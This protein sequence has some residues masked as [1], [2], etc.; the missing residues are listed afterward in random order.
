[1]PGFY[2]LARRFR[3][4]EFPSG[5]PK[6]G[7]PGV[8]K[9]GLPTKEIQARRGFAFVNVSKTCLA[10][11][12]DPTRDALRRVLR[13]PGQ[14]VRHRLRWCTSHPSSLAYRVVLASWLKMSSPSAVVAA[15]FCGASRPSSSARC[16]WQSRT[17]AR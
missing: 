10:P 5:V 8:R 11:C 4:G 12:P 9:F 6:S 7:L 16:L 2:P 13:H 1:M 14:E 15:I 17:T 3:G